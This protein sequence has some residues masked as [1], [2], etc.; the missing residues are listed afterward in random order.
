MNAKRLLKSLVAAALLGCGA[1]YGQ[2]APQQIEVTVRPSQSV[3]QRVADE[4]KAKELRK[5]AEEKLATEESARLAEKSPRAL[6][7]LARTVY[8]YYDTS[9]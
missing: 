3:E 5:A 1:A 4:M 7:A 2:T 9:Y 8:V 6:L